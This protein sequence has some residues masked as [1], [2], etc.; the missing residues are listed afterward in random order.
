MRRVLVAINLAALTACQ[1]SAAARAPAGVGDRP[2]PAALPEPGVYVLE[3]AHGLPLPADLKRRGYD[4]RRGDNFFERI[5][6]GWL[7]LTTDSGYPQYQTIICA[8]LVDSAGRVPNTLDRG[9]AEGRY[10]EAGGRVYFSD[11]VADGPV[12]SIAVRVHGDTVEFARDVYVRDPTAVRPRNLI[13][14]SI[15]AAVRGPER[16]R[17]PG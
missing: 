12:A 7:Y 6:A 1:P 8:D 2:G 15:C 16:A 13:P 14:V 11:P 10:W 3:Q 17:T 4:P 5:L 9:P